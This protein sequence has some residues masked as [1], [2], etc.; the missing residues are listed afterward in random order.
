M[1]PRGR[2]R[3]PLASIGEEP[4]PRFSL[5]NERTLLAWSRTAM[6]LIVAG[7]TIGQLLDFHSSAARAIASFSPIGVGLAIG[8]VSLRRWVAIERALRLRQPL[9][10][11]HTSVTLALALVV[12]AVAAVA[13]VTLDAAA[14]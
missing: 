2:R 4:D 6:A 10:L 9:P 12:L 14:R 8:L 13:S 5:A 1:G 7:L 11:A 3:P